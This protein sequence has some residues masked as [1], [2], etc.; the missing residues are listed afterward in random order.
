MRKVLFLFSFFLLSCSHNP[1]I[2]DKCNMEI[3]N[4]TLTPEILWSFG[5]LGDVSVAPDGENLVYGVTYYDIKE[6][7]SNRE[8]F[9]LNIKDGQTRRITTTFLSSF[10]S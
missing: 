3:K 2:I 8:L 10:Y 7:K 5:R 9:V 4:G 1:N 6:N